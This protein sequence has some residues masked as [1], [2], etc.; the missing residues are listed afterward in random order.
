MKVCLEAVFDKNVSNLHYKI[1]CLL[2]NSEQSV[3]KLAKRFK[4]SFEQ[5]HE[6]G[7]VEFKEKNNYYGVWN[8][9]RT[10]SIKE[11]KTIVIME[12]SFT[13]NINLSS[14]AEIIINKRTEYVKSINEESSSEEHKWI[15]DVKEED[16]YYWM[17]E[18]ARFYIAIKELNNNN[19]NEVT[20]DYLKNNTGLIVNNINSNIDT[21]SHF[22]LLNYGNNSLKLKLVRR[23]STKNHT[24]TNVSN[25]KKIL[26]NHIIDFSFDYGVYD[27]NFTLKAED[28]KSVPKNKCGFY[29][30]HNREK[31]IVYIGKSKDLQSRLV[32]HVNGLTHTKKFSDQMY[33]VSLIIIDKEKYNNYSELFEK[34]LI[35]TFSPTYNKVFN[36]A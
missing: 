35:K 1:L 36:V 3:V 11:D 8:V 30:F 22:K 10:P 6:L 18:L 2:L 19:I 27:I 21:L 12:N 7:Y 13:N 20:K 26:N 32:S 29:I 9:Y 14:L 25:I 34:D 28:S 31:E 24:S 15:F 17:C 16:M 5:L 4:K 23:I 33:Y